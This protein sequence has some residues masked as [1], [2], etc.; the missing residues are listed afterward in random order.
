MTCSFQQEGRKR[1]Q[2]LTQGSEARGI[3]GSMGPES[4]TVY[5]LGILL[6]QSKA[7]L[8]WKFLGPLQK[9]ARDLQVR[10]T[11]GLKIHVL[12]RKS[13]SLLNCFTFASTIP[14][15][16]SETKFFQQ[17]QSQVSFH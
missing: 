4:I 7:L 6:I 3:S 10:R 1:R 5:A 15:P 9:H 2:P 8:L 16:H 14:R 11:L 12:H 17:G 13:P